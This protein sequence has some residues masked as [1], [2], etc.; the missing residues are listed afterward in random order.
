MVGPHAFVENEHWSE[1]RMK[2]EF[3]ARFVAIL[4]KN[5]KKER[6][7]YFSN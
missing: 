3:H 7:V 6:L 4:Q 1:V 5:Y 2:E